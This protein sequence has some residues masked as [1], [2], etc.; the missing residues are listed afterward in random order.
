[1][2][3]QTKLKGNH[4]QFFG[5]LPHSIGVI[6]KLTNA[7]LK[8]WVKSKPIALEFDSAEVADEA[9]VAK[10]EDLAIKKA[11]KRS[12]DRLDSN[13]YKAELAW[14]QHKAEK[15]AAEKAEIMKTLK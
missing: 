11:K 9:A 7:E 13:E 3:I 12:D 2:R 8:E 4:V 10:D 15:E 1:M 5:V 14:N 6:S